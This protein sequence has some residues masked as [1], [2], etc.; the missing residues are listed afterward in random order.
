MNPEIKQK[1]LDALRSGRYL[2]G[3]GK[4][5][6]RDGITGE[7][8][9]CCLGVLCEVLGIKS[10]VEESEYTTYSYDGNFDVLPKS[11]IAVSGL[12]TP[13]GLF[14]M[15][16]KENELSALNDTRTSFENIADLIEV[17]F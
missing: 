15:D 8:Y 12:S 13:T 3:Q 2:Q 11:V 1:W 9:Y 6:Y 10:E 4:L 16:G 17:Y 14:V 5:H 7:H